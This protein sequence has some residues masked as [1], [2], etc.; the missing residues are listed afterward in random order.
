MRRLEISLI[1]V[2]NGMFFYK[3]EEEEKEVVESLPEL[4][5]E[6]KPLEVGIHEV[7]EDCVGYPLEIDR[8]DHP[9]GVTFLVVVVHEPVELELEMVCEQV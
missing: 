5:E 1:Y 4:V 2:D 9:V 3:G 6:R 8:K 7:E